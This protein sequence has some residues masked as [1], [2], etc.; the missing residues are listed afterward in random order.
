MFRRPVF[1][2]AFSLICIASVVFAYTYFSKAFPIVNLDLRMDRKMAFD[3]AKELALKYHWGPK[4]FRQ[5]ASFTLNSSVQNFVELEAGGNEAFSKMLEEKIYSPYTWMVRHFKEGEVNE[6]R[7]FFT[8]QG[9]PFGFLEKLAE[10]EPGA[11][12]VRDSARYI[13]ETTAEKE[14]HVNFSLYKLV[15]ESEE[16]QIGGRLDHKFVY[17]R[18]DVQIGEGKYRLRLVIGGDKLIELTHFVK[19]PE[20]FSR[21]YEEM[22]SVNTTISAFANIVMVVLYILGGCIIGLFF[23]LRQ[24]WVIW[25]NPLLWGIFIAFLQIFAIVNQWQLTWMNY[26]TAISTRGFLMQQIVMLLFMF[27]GF[28]VF[29]SLSFMAAECLSRRA[30]PHHIQLWHS[31]KSNIANSPAL[32]G[33]TVSGY[34]LVGFFFAFEVILYFMATKILGWWTPSSALFHPDIMAHYFP[35]FSSI[36]LSL[37]AGFVEEC[38]FRAVPIAG[39]ALLGQRFGYRKVWIAAAFIIQAIVFGAGHAGYANQPAYARMVELIIPSFGLGILY[40]YFGLLPAIILHF[41]YDVVWF[42]LPLFASS[43]PGIWLDQLMII[44]LTLLPFWIII[45]ARIQI[46]KWGEIAEEHFNHSWLPPV[47]VEMPPAEILITEPTTIPSKIIRWLPLGGVIGIILWLFATNFENNAPSLNINRGEA[48]KFAQKMLSERNVSLP[49]PWKTLSFVEA[50]KSVN[51]RFIWQEGGKENYKKL[52]NKY[53]PP[54][55]WIVRFAKFEGDVAE[56][57]EEY[58]V[59]YA[60]EE[61]VRLQH[62]LPEK[63]PGDSLTEEQARS[64]ADSVIAEL[65]NLN[66]EKLKKISAVPQKRPARTDWVIT[67]ADT[68]N[69]PLTKGEARIDVTIAG[70]KVTNYGRYIHVPEEWTRQ[71]RDKRNKFT[72]I[73]VFCMIL[74]ILMALAS[75]I[76]SIVHWSRRNF[77][78]SVFL[79]F[80]ILLICIGFIGQFN[81]WPWRIAHFSTAQPLLNQTL[82]SFASSIVGLLFLSAC[83]A[84]IIGFVQRWKSQQTHLDLSRALLLGLSIGILI[85]GIGS[86]IEM[87]APSLDLEP[88][89]AKYGSLNTYSSMV[90]AALNSVTT[91]ISLTSIFLL[92]M[93]ALTRFSKEWSKRKVLLSII[94]ILLFLFLGA[95]EVDKGILYWLINGISYGIILLISYYYILRHHLVLI[96]FMI[97]AMGILSELKEGSMQAYPEAMGGALLGTLL[98]V[99]L[100]VYWYK[101]LVSDK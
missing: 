99:I 91:Y 25:R 27:L 21:R 45:R 15:E 1:W 63:T 78:P 66:A 47:K 32:L 18:Q 87:Y 3:S 46:G 96:P 5:A 56:R 20:A 53:L 65:Y 94:T 29:F 52:I 59:Y 101:I 70:N 55:R 76:Y 86:V 100:S 90:D 69:Y 30:F 13:A 77:S 54:P 48:E 11:S 39:A 35:W 43:A 61:H 98:I 62:L 14:W 68:L 84:L 88:F 64:L 82:T 6:T 71:E 38:L 79:R 24:R 8:P 57:A 44:I 31:W 89:W 41:T 23:L 75:I 49:A 2:I 22:R 50:P 92:I 72:I 80:F 19:I 67:Y 83:I 26:D 9:T 93:I 85:E 36:A 58:K 28:S 60:N 17:E 12:I 40:L 95:G 7:I 16:R 73:S 10:K 34:L 33:R 74:L 97:G 51:H 4:G 42:A 37:Q 81:G